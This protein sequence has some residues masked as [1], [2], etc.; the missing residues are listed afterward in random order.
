MRSG[1]VPAVEYAV[2]LALIA[3]VSLAAIHTLGTNAKT[4]I[5]NV[6]N[7]LAGSSTKW[8]IGAIYGLAKHIPGRLSNVTPADQ[9]IRAVF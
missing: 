9:P 1:A 5:I 6:C 4:A 3:V 7:P 2:M 8:L